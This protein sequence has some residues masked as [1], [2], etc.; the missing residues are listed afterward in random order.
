MTSSVSAIRIALETA[1]ESLSPI[2]P[3][4][5]L[6][7]IA[8]VGVGAA[9]VFATTGPHGLPTGTPL[10]LIGVVGSTPALAGLYLAVVLSPTTFNLQN[11]ATKANVSVTI[12][13]TG[14]T[15]QAALTAYQNVLHQ[16]PVTLPHQELNLMFFKP[17]EPTTGSGFYIE[18][19]VFQVT[20]AYPI[21]TGLTSILERAAVIRAG[22]HKGLNFTNSGVTVLIS[23]TPEFGRFDENTH[24]VLL[25]V[26]IAFSAQ[27]YS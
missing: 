7:S 23:S 6:A 1:L 26:K 19:G 21:G 22:F 14:G 17:D 9:A 18:Q 4:S 27:I 16:S 8:T 2:I 25:P 15:V 10:R 20:L 3:S 5:T 12:A 24:Y 11:A 13:G